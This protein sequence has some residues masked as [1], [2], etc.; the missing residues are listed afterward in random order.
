[1]INDARGERDVSIR[2]RIAVHRRRHYPYCYFCYNIN[3]LWVK[4]KFA[5]IFCSKKSEKPLLLRY[6]TIKYKSIK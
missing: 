6:Y 3:L 1:M 2:A 4:K 5:F